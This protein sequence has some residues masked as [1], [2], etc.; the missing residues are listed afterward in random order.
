MR[1]GD[2]SRWFRDAINDEELAADAE[3]VERTR[4]A[5]RAESLSLLRAAIE[6]RYTLPAAAPISIPGT[7][8]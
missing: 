6:S 7:R 3:R 4:N 5:T 8:K 2:Y 1:A